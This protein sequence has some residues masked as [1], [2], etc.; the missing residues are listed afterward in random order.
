MILKKMAMALLAVGMTAGVAAAAG[1]ADKV[2]NISYV[3]SPFNLQS[4]VM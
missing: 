2:L 1:D 4:I 3:K